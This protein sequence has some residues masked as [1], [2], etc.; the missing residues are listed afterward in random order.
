MTLAHD[1]TLRNTLV[2]TVVDAID[3]G[4]AN[5]AGLLRFLEGANSRA[6]VTLQNPAF[7]AAASQAASLLGV[8]L[9]SAAAAATS[10]ALDGFD[11]QDRD[12]NLV[13]NG[14]IGGTSS[15]EDIEMADPTLAVNDIIR[16]T[17][18]VYNAHA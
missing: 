13:F 16:V 5:A 4:S 12:R 10:V 3:A 9:D 7:G 2:N 18:F 14:S 11:F 17:S 6:E 8:P 15:G 1:A